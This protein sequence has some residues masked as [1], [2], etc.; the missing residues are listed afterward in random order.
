MYNSKLTAAQ[1]QLIR[2]NASETLTTA[3]LAKLCGIEQQLVR[4]FIRKERLPVKKAQRSNSVSIKRVEDG[5]FDVNSK[6]WM[7]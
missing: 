4:Y 1:K 2:D 6:D 5:F 3:K 7:I